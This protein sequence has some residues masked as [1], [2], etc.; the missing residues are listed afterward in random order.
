MATAIDDL[1]DSQSDAFL[2][3]KWAYQMGLWDGRSV[4][5]DE[6]AMLHE[7]IQSR[8]MKALDQERASPQGF[9]PFTAF[10]A[11]AGSADADRL[12][13]EKDIQLLDL[14]GQDRVVPAGFWKSVTK[15]YKKHKTA[16]LITAASIAVVATG[17]IIAVSLLG[18]GAVDSS[19]KQKP[20][21]QPSKTP[22]PSSA[23][24]PKTSLDADRAKGLSRPGS[25]SLPP[26]EPIADA[27]SF[28]S[29]VDPLCSVASGSAPFS[30][31]TITSSGADAGF[32][33][34]GKVVFSPT[35]VTL[36]QQYTSYQ[37]ILG[38]S[39][40]CS[41]PPP[42]SSN[43]NFYPLPSGLLPPQPPPGL[44]PP[45]KSW[46]ASTFETIGKG[47]IEPELLTPED[48][49]PMP[50]FSSQFATPGEQKPH[51]KICGINGVDTSLDLANSHA[52]YIRRLA[53]GH[54]VTWIHNCTHGILIDLAEAF[55]LNYHGI[56]P[57]TSDLLLKTWMEF[58]EINA[59]RP[60][61]KLL[62]FCHSQGAI[63]VKITLEKAPPHIRNRIIV[64][65][66]APA[67]VVSR[68]ICYNSYNFACKKDIVPYAEIVSAGLD[69]FFASMDPEPLVKLPSRL[70][71][72]METRQEMI[73]LPPDPNCKDSVHFMQNP[74]FKKPLST[75]IVEYFEK[76]GE[77]D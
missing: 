53:L 30:N 26:Q 44:A 6:A 21:R 72:V 8:I 77:Y 70:D 1:D 4:A 19:S 46:V 50:S 17:S 54:Q 49:F 9:G 58:D 34:Q 23:A 62:Q 38:Q 59:D 13:L 27:K 31:S 42:N 33:H 69:D 76:D 14:Y 32:Q 57:N 74:A 55:F 28:T 51:L 22:S 61:A 16:I 75:V 47:L 71:K 56:A 36:N 40:T 5:W 52:E 64:V 11:W 35:G 18:A 43:L 48:T 66:I 39:E 15:F 67:A 73:Y 7:E 41:L 24:K 12:L 29:F 63:Q 2:F 20:P 37:E 3:A 65:A 25:I 68:E 60:K 45:K 10:L